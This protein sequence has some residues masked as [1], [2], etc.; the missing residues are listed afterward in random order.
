VRLDRIE[1][2]LRRRSPWE[3]ID[4]GL[5]MVRHW[6]GPLYR[7]WLTTVLPVAVGI[8]ALLWQWPQA[9]MLVV[10]WMKPVADRVLLKFFSE[11]TFGEPP[12]PREV[13]RS[14][15]ALLLRSGLFSR[16]T[17]R[18]FTPYRSLELP[19]LQLEGQRGKALRLR[20]RTLFRKVAGHAI[21]LMQV[22]FCVVAILEI[23]QV[24][25]VGLLIPGDALSEFSLFEMFQ[26]EANLFA[27]H[28]FNAAWLIAESIV[29]PFYVAGGFSLYLSRRND[30]EGWDIEMAF[31]HMAESHADEPARSSG[32]A[33]W[34]MAAVAL[35]FGAQLVLTVP[36]A[37][38]ASVRPPAEKSGAVSGEA[39]RVARE[40][41]SDP[42]FGR[43]IEETRWQL[44]DKAKNPER[45]PGEFLAWL[46]AVAG[47]LAEGTRW[48]LYLLMAAALA[49]LLV[50]LYRYSGRLAGKPSGS[51]SR[52]PETL[53]G[54]DL[55]PASLPADISA[56]AWA[57][58]LAG[59]VAAALSLLYRGAL[60]AAIERHR[61]PFCEGDT[62]N[63]CLQRLAGHAGEAAR[64]Y[65]A[66]LLEAWKASAY[67]GSPPPLADV[68][69]LCR[70]W[71]E[72]FGR[73]GAA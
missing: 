42:V 24:Q 54:L 16:L 1:L 29:E 48:L 30:L 51:A 61:V 47:W 9:G 4:L 43:E 46:R 59:R 17:L 11:A 62:E 2:A 69:A 25:L 15:P 40:V 32:R 38:A 35:L 20:R 27:Y 56:A 31:R 10:W 60:V 7:V 41:L 19:M 21:Y 5:V 13:W 36:E 34:M 52:A 63:V 26:G 73:G 14:L 53:F 23:G 39:S 64:A 58:A 70:E 65:F 57:E 3:A 50:A 18:R 12:T 72:H 49:A 67:A 66:A 68:R 55:R 37:L 33:G 22:C 44:R 28:C 8:L 6:R 71:P 45:K